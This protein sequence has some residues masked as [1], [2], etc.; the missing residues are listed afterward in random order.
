MQRRSFL[1]QVSLASLAVGFVPNFGLANFYQPDQL[2]ELIPLE[3]A[4]AQI[5]HGALHFPIYDGKMETFPFDWLLQV[6][7]NVFFQNGFQAN[8][9]DDLEIVSILLRD[10][11][12]EGVE[13]LES[14][15]VQ[16]EARQTSMLIGEEITTLPIEKA[17]LAEPLATPSGQYLDLLH[18]QEN[19][20]FDKTWTQPHDLFLQVLQGEVTCQGKLLQP[21]TGLIL[22]ATSELQLS[23]VVN[24]RIL[25][26]YQ[27]CEV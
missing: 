13:E 23:T 4:A 8:A 26:L 2:A 6:Q 3:G 21:D 10:T 19:N 15:Q 11:Q 7:R 14:V 22:R 18:C 5:R 20:T 24:S 12:L 27:N 17:N 1:R 25:L 9:T 16:L